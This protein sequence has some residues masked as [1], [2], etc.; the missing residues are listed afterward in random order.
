MAIAVH[1]A[2]WQVRAACK[3]PQAAAFFPPVTTERRDEKRIREAHAKAICDACPVRS[4]CLDFA[5][6]IKEPHGIW[7]GLSE[8]E[9]RRSMS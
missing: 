4:D 8:V 7:G 6:A 2:E 9:R 5:M 1:Q 3:G